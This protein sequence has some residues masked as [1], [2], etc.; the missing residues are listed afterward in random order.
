MELA[1]SAWTGRVRSCGVVVSVPVLAWEGR[2][3][4]GFQGERVHVWGKGF[5]KLSIR[6]D[7]AVEV[8]I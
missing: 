8:G 2:G 1:A 4:Y 5:S 3:G 7:T 6:A